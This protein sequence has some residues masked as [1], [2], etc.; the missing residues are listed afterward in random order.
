MRIPWHRVVYALILVVGVAYGYDYASVR[1]RMIENKPGNP[2]D[3]VSYPHLLAI[4]QKGNKVDYELDAQSPMESE[5]CVHSLFPH[6]GYTPCWYV[7]RR[8]KSPTQ[9]TIL[10]SAFVLRHVR[11]L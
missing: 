6:N 2:F 8:S 9:M 7:L 3:V 4:P 1:R 11:G 5:P 10:A